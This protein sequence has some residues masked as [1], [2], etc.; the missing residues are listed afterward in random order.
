MGRQRRNPFRGFLD[1]MSEMN[2][3]Q[4]KWISL[5]DQGRAGAHGTP[6]TAWIPD[7]DIYALENDLVIRCAL[8]GVRREDVEIS[9]SGGVLMISGERRGEPKNPRPIHYTREL[10]YGIFR[11]VMSLPEGIT[12]SDIS[13]R[14]ENGLLEII[15]RGGASATE[16]ERIEIG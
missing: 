2:R 12:K 15:V 5:N 11:R 7:A 16:P 8:A 4:Q 10:R 13:A 1:V 6:A 9:L 3:A 14:F